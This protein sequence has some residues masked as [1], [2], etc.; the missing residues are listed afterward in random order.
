MSG[1]IWELHKQPQK[2]DYDVKLR[3][4]AFKV[5]DL[6]YRH[7]T[8]H[9]KGLSRKLCPVYIGPY[10]VVEVLSPYL[11]RWEDACKVYKFLGG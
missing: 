9:R 10:L 5:G 3:V 6:V 8:A 4:Q 7:N 1:R 2:K 11:Y